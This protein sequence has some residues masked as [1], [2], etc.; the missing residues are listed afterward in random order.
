MKSRFNV[1]LKEPYGVWTKANQKALYRSQATAL[2]KQL[3][4]SGRPISVTILAVGFKPG[5]G[6]V[7]D[8]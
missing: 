5:E 1:W 6:Q 7:S 2:L 3:S 4:E 8:G